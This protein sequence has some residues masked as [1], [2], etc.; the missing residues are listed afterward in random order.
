MPSG[1][2]GRAVLTKSPEAERRFEDDYSTRAHRKKAV[3]RSDYRAVDTMIAEGKFA[4][5]DKLPPDIAS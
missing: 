4:P 2:L 3:D 5:G 1:Q